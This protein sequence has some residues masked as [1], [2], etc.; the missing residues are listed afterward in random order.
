M[1]MYTYYCP[2][3]GWRGDRIT[4]IVDRDRQ[5]CA[6]KLHAAEGSS[7]YCGCDLHR[8][9]IPETT[10]C[11]IDKRWKFGVIDSLG[12]KANVSTKQSKGFGP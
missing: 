12:R 6:C 4:P 9:E 2:V 5:L 8:V 3:C 10:V 7:I 11:R 1:P